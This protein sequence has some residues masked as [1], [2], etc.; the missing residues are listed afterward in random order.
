MDDIKPG[1]GT[2]T[3]AVMAGG[4]PTERLQPTFSKA[5]LSELLVEPFK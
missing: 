2:I 4:S 1:G 3:A 5:A